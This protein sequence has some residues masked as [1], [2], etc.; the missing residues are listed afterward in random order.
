MSEDRKQTHRMIV[1]GFVRALCNKYDM[2]IPKDF[3]QIIFMF[4]YFGLFKFE[5]GERVK[6]EDNTI[7]NIDTTFKSGWNTTVIGEWM[8][9][10]STINHIYTIKIKIIKSKGS[11]RIGI[12]NDHDS[13]PYTNLNMPIQMEE[14][15]YNE[16]GYCYFERTRQ[17]KGD[18]YTSGDVVIM[19]LDLKSLSLSAKVI[20]TTNN[21]TNEQDKILFKPGEIL[22][23]KY[24]WKVTI[25]FANDSCEVM[26]IY[27]Q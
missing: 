19:T 27:Q 4:F 24:K 11:F 1:D 17:S 2:K 5:H 26:E 20:K 9:P 3:I 21:G 15:S 8:D 18:S 25:H 12:I 14:Y 23:A 22:K 16:K 13:Y 6:I 7:T 10:D